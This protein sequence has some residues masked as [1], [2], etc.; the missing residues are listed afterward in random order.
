MITDFLLKVGTSRHVVFSR[1]NFTSWR[2]GTIVECC[3]WLVRERL[4]I[5]EGFTSYFS[6]ILH[7]VQ[8]C[9]KSVVQ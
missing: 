4:P 1:S 3:S 6:I 7:L 5:S 9:I 8:Y 2:H